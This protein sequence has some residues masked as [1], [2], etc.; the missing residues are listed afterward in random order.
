[1]LMGKQALT[2]LLADGARVE[3]QRLGK[4]HRRR[5]RKVAV[6]RLT[7][8]LK[9]RARTRAGGKLLQLAGKRGKQL[10]ADG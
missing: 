9:R 1:M 7:R 5:A 4:L 8:L 6:R 3:L 10:A 2:Q